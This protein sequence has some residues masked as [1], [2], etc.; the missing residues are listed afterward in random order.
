MQLK[1]NIQKKKKK[2]KTKSSSNKPNDNF[3]KLP[4]WC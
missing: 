2:R 4:Y 3:V 1:S